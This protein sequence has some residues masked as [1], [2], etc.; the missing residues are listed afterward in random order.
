M[1]ISPE[2][3]L[4]EASRMALEIRFKDQIIAGLEAENTRLREPQPDPPQEAQP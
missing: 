1:N 2:Q 3:L 4:A